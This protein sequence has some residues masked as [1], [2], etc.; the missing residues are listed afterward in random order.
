MVEWNLDVNLEGSYW[1]FWDLLPSYNNAV[2]MILD[3]K[4][5]VGLWKLQATRGPNLN[6]EL[7]KFSIDQFYS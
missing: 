6:N 3:G 1:H 5:P 7:N 4:T 2:L